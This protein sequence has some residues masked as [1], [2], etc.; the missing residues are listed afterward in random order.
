MARTGAQTEK[1]VQRLH[2]VCESIQEQPKDSECKGIKG[3]TEEHESFK[4]EGPS[5]DLLDVFNVGAA[6]KV[7]RYEI[8]AYEGLIRLAEEMGHRV[9]AL[10]LVHVQLPGVHRIGF[11]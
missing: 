9:Q 10:I 4:E 7:E 8:S 5:D 6:I 11:V 2:Q 1:Q 3:L